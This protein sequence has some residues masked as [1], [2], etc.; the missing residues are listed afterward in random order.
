MNDSE[1]I[2]KCVEGL[3]KAVRQIMKQNPAGDPEGGATGA[4]PPLK[5]NQLFF[6]SSFVSECLKNKALI[7]RESIK[8]TLQLPGPLSGPWTPPLPKVNSVPRS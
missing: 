1:I 4:R 2:P 7:A 3:W 5:L 6:K 8:A